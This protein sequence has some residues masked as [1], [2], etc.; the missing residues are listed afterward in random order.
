[1]RSPREAMGDLADSNEAG[2]LGRAR[3]EPLGHLGPVGAGLRAGA[4]D[5]QSPAAGRP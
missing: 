2:K 4:Q 3:P 1:M 5:A